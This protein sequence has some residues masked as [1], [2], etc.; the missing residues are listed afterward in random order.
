MFVDLIDVKLEDSTYAYIGR[1]DEED[2][3][4][5]FQK[6]L[7]R[8]VNILE[9]FINRNFENLSD[10][11]FYNFISEVYS[12]ILNDEDYLNIISKMK[13]NKYNRFMEI[14]TYMT[15]KDLASEG[16]GKSFDCWEQLYQVK[17][18][19]AVAE[20]TKIKYDSILTKKEI[21]NLIE[22]NKIVIVQTKPE[23]IYNKLQ[24]NETIEVMPSI[25]LELDYS[26]GEATGCICKNN[27]FSY[28]VSLLRKKFTK[29]KILKD[30]RSYINELQEQI[31][32][33]LSSGD[34]NYLYEQ[35]SKLCNDWY[36]NSEEK[37]K[38]KSLTKRINN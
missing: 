2:I 20:D 6:E 4:K 13:N 16:H 10:D 31:N 14:G 21:K 37:Q 35:V 17:Y 15:F 23:P 8:N 27:N 38:I 11:E 32:R 30:M 28:F 5:T 3:L 26:N 34:G 9:N 33:I 12:I 22:N 25:D 29:K 18:I 7:K 19:I 1:T 24:R 36:N